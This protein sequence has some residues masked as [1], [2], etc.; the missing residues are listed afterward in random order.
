MNNLQRDREVIERARD[1]VSFQFAVYNLQISLIEMFITRNKFPVIATCF[2]NSQALE[3]TDVHPYLEVIISSDPRLNNHC[4]FVV[5]K[6]SL[7]CTP[8]SGI[9]CLLR[10]GSL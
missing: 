7:S 3:M 5:E 2:L 9:I 10:C 6:S 4:D 8:F 1:R